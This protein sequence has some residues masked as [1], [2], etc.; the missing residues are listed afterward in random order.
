MAE[1]QTVSSMPKTWQPRPVGRHI[2][3]LS[4]SARRGCTL[5]IGVMQATVVTSVCSAALITLLIAGCS[6]QSG[7][8]PQG[9]IL[10][11]GLVTFSGQAREV[12]DPKVP[13]GKRW[14]VE[15]V[16]F[17]VQTNRIPARIGVRFGVSYQISNLLTDDGTDVLHTVVYRHP[18]I[19]LPSGGTSTVNERLGTRPVSD[20]KAKGTAV[21]AFDE[22]YELAPGQW[23]ISIVYKGLTLC[24]QRFTVYDEKSGKSN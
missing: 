5:R 12:A 4:L 7:T 14:H 17:T 1:N 6:G 20:G 13:T 23:E 11:F 2:C 19:P 24:S 15:D 3:F 9:R 22:D 16:T 21:Y 18:P 8:D 10:N